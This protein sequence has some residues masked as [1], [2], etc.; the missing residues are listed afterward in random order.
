MTGDPFAKMIPL[1]S[2]DDRS[3]ST[4]D[5][6]ASTSPMIPLP[7]RPVASGLPERITFS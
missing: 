6:S 7:Q 5:P 2:I 3:T 1:R 4:D